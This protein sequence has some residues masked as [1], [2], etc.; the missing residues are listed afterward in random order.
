LHRYWLF[1]TR[2]RCVVSS[3]R[4]EALVV[5]RGDKK[6]LIER[7]LEARPEP[8]CG[9]S[10]TYMTTRAVITPKYAPDLELCGDRNRSV[11]EWTPADIAHPIIVPRSDSEAFASLRSGIPL[12]VRREGCPASLRASAPGGDH[13]DA[14]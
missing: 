12:H 6:E 8:P 3:V 7:Y 5:V 14:R 4:G 9:S 10:G 2:P 1:S 13:A 11:L